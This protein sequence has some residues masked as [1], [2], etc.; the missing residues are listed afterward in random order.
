MTLLRWQPQRDC[1]GLRRQFNDLFE[2]DFFHGDESTTVSCWTPA[3]DIYESKDEY[4]FNVELPGISKD[5]VNIEFENGIF[6][7]N[8]ARKEEKEVKEE[9]V[10]RVEGCYGS[11]SRSF[12]LPKNVNDKKI[13]ARMKDGILEVKI[14]K[15]E[16]VKAKSIPINNS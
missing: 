2:R 7:I 3:T 4:V 5:D 13:S 9:N 14:P 8:G 16:E 15:A 11:F 1:S 10:H 12:R 6:S